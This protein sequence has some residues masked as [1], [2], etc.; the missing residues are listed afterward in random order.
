M[1]DRTVPVAAIAPD[2]LTSSD[3]G[4]MNNDDVTN[5]MSPAFQGP[6]EANAKVRVLANGTVVGEGVVTSNGRWE[7]TVEPLADGAYTITY[8]LE[9]LAGNISAPSEGLPIWIDTAVPNTP[10]LDLV[11][12]SDTGRSDVDNITM[13]NTPMVTVT[14][15]DTVNGNG[16]PFPNDIK[17]RIYDRPGTAA[18]NGEVLLVQS[19]TGIPGFSTNGFFTHQ[20]SQTLNDDFDGGDQRIGSR[21][22]SPQFEARSGRPRRQRQS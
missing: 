17:Y 5:K 16:N 6:G 13:N 7:V 2:M 22:R 8:L 3:S 9:D 15:D 10:L 20:L 18:T 1:I 12:A 11:A 4:M 21:R 19:F 14:A